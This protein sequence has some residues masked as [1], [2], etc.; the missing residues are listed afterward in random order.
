[1]FACMFDV[2]I[3]SLDLSVTAAQLHYEKRKCT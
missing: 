2:C 1:M 3:K